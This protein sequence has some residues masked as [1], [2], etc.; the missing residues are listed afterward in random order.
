MG[1]ISNTRRRR[2]YQSVLGVAALFAVTVAMADDPRLSTTSNNPTLELESLD[3]SLPGAAFINRAA[4]LNFV[5]NGPVPETL[6]PRVWFVLYLRCG[7]DS[8]GVC[9]ETTGFLDV[10]RGRSRAYLGRVENADLVMVPNDDGVRANGRVVFELGDAL[11]A[12][13]TVSVV[14]SFEDVGFVEDRE[15]VADIAHPAVVRLFPALAD[16]AREIGV[17]APDDPSAFE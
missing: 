7:W 8:R 2:S 6:D 15:W 5:A 1:R 3:I 16:W 9:H 11:D 4:F 14:F 13:E 12:D 10:W 17:V